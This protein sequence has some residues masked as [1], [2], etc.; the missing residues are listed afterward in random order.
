ML[1]ACTL[2]VS[3]APPFSHLYLDICGV[4]EHVDQLPVLGAQPVRVHDLPASCA[5]KAVLV[6]LGMVLEIAILQH[7]GHT[8]QLKRPGDAVSTSAPVSMTETADLT[9][10]HQHARTESLR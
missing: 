8:A 9:D 6:K 10:H 5:L 7:A 1:A 2:Q 4:H 3:R